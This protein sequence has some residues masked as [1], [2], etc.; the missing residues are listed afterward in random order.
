GR[1]QSGLYLEDPHSI[2]I[3]STIE[4]E[5]TGDSQRG[6]GGCS[7]IYAGGKSLPTDVRR[8]HGAACC[9]CCV[10]VSRCQITLRGLGNCITGVFCS[11]ECP[12]REANNRS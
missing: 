4:R 8:K 2:R 6:L 1:G 3:A 11:R 7:S 9:T 12:R 10:V 5:V